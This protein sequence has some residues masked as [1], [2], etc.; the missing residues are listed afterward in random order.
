MKMQNLEVCL[1]DLDSSYLNLKVWVICGIKK[2]D[3]NVFLLKLEMMILVILTFDG[4]LKTKV[5]PGWN[6]ALYCSFIPT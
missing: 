3:G 2:R 4:L 1:S 6:W 5:D